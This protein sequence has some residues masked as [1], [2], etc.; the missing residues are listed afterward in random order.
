MSPG[1]KYTLGRFGVF[2]VIF[3][4]LL[5]VPMNMLLRLIV[6][7]F[8]SAAVSYF[9]LRRWRAELTDQMAGSMERRRAEKDRLREALAGN[10]PGG[11]TETT[12]T[13]P[14]AAP[15]ADTDRDGRTPPQP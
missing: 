14:G 9:V 6:A 1:V 8:A 13:E 5:V 11:T 15:P 2:V 12:A 10:E 3:A 4:V 7:I